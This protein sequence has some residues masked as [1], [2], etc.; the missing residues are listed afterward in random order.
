MLI[1]TIISVITLAVFLG[2]GVIGNKIIR[3]EN[4]K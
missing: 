3:S 4:Q 1:M 2:A